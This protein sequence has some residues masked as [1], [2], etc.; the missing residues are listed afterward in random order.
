MKEENK[1]PSQAPEKKESLDRVK[2]VEKSVLKISIALIIALLVLAVCVLKI[3]EDLNKLYSY[4]LDLYEVMH[5]GQPIEPAGTSGI[6]Q[7]L[8][9]LHTS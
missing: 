4:V 3:T 5:L 6:A 7:I 9:W 1:P 2:Q 8:P